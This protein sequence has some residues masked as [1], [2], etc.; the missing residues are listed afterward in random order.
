MSA[1]F[2]CPDGVIR[3]SAK[4][5]DNCYIRKTIRWWSSICRC[6]FGA[7]RKFCCGSLRTL[8]IASKIIS[9][10]QYESWSTRYYVASTSWRI[11][12]RNWMK[13]QRWL[14]MTLFLL[15]A[16]AI[17]DKLQDGVPETIHTLQ[18]AGIKIW[19]LTGDRQETAINIG[20]SCKLLKWRYESF[21]INEETKMIKD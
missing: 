5:P 14:K 12:L 15:G 20:M 16:T 2:R 11:D 6:Y 21:N 3:F 1:I 7:F 13:L 17:E 18:S 4:V 9:E 8:C 10:E 19:V